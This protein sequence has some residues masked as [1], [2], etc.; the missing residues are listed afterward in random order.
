MQNMAGWEIINRSLMTI[1]KILGPVR[2]LTVQD[3][4]QALALASE[5]KEDRYI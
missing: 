2:K 4:A 3:I 5:R 1:A